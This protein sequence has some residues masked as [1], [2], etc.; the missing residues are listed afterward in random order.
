MPLDVWVIYVVKRRQAG[1]DIAD[2]ADLLGGKALKVL[3]R[4]P[5]Q[6]KDITDAET[7]YRQALT[8]ARQENKRVFLHLGAPSCGWC[9][10]LEEFLEEPDVA[11]I[12]HKDYVIVKIDLSKMAGAEALASRLR[13]NQGGIPWF[14]ILDSEGKSLVTADGPSGNIGYP[15]TPEEKKHFMY[16]LKET[17]KNLTAEDISIIENN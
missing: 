8:T 17:A 3:L 9:R 2:F 13:T 6:I 11:K 15:V 10:K 5:G 4:V 1:G 7:V 12:F 16:M 14:V